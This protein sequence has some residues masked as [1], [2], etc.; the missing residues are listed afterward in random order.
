MDDFRIEDRPLMPGKFQSAQRIAVDGGY[1]AAIHIPLLS[2]RTFNAGDGPQTQPAA[3]VSR[4]FAQLYFPGQD[5][6]GH[7]IQMGASRAAHE[8]WVRIVGITGDASYT[9]I[10]R[11]VEPAVYLNAD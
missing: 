9:W 1:F 5:P 10:D 4:K 2:G 7:R 8:P 3:I 11:V 6:I